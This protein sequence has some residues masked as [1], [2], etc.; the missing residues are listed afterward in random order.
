MKTHSRRRR[1]SW[2]IAT[3]LAVATLAACAATA[4]AVEPLEPLLVAED[5][6]SGSSED[7]G[8]GTARF[9]SM[10][11]WGTTNVG[12]SGLAH[13]IGE[14]NPHFVLTLGDNFYETGVKSAEDPLFDTI[15]EKQFS[16]KNLDKTPFVAVCGNHD[17]YGNCSAQIAYSS[18]SKNKRWK[19]PHFYYS[20]V[21]EHNGVKVFVLALDTWRLV[22]GDALL[23]YDVRTGQAAIRS[24]D[25]LDEA[26][27]TGEISAE[28]ARAL[29]A[30][31]PM[32]ASGSGRSA[33]GHEQSQ[34]QIS[35]FID[36][37][38]WA[39]IEEQLASAKSQGVD[40]IV[41]M[42]HF[43]VYSATVK[44]H[45]DTAILKPRLA[46]ILREYGVHAYF[47]GHDH[48]LQHIQMEQGGVNYFGS[49]AGGKKHDT[50][51]WRYPGARGLAPGAI[52][53]MYHEASKSE[54]TTTFLSAVA[55]GSIKEVYRVMFR[56]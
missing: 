17:Y 27:R 50:M 29:K 37:K 41:A 47:S 49:G 53:V 14:R 6:A 52:G 2:L 40:W 33:S 9:V 18:R 10:G 30:R 25:A 35:P 38:Q 43:P 1:T 19:M 8:S 13:E 51:N 28:G 3:A 4:W 36:H 56:K 12:S 34:D 54:L 7:K 42:G 32:L 55:D 44:E 22:G 15:F 26:V 48:V 16:H 24:E 20:R 39:W 45:G 21:E 5:A 46:K 23:A 11:D 31:V